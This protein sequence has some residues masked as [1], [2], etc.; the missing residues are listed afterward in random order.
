MVVVRTDLKLS[1]GKLAVQVAHAAT[2]CAITAKREN[3]K[4]FKRWFNEGQKK[5][6]VKV[7]GKEELLELKQVARAKGLIAH[8]IS[9]AGLTEVPSG[10][11]TC[12]GVGP[13]PNNL[14]DAITGNL[15][16]L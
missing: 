5:V 12:L 1:Q 3:P 7:R 6:V 13:A 14:V 16:L 11:M 15:P 2:T 9:D 8:T 4:Y 10:T